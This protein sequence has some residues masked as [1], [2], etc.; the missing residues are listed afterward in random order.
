MNRTLILAAALLATSA[1]TLAA[2]PTR[3]EQGRIQTVDAEQG[4]HVD[5]LERLVNQNSGSRNLDGVRKVRDM[6][7]SV[8]QPEMSS[9]SSAGLSST[10]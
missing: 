4:R 9:L 3:Q 7:V 8:T 6:L 1:P 5:L 2:A 10:T